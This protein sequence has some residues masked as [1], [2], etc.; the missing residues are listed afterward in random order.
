MFS[1][2]V[3]DEQCTPPSTYDEFLVSINLR[4]EDIMTTEIANPNL[5]RRA[6]KWLKQ[7]AA[8]VNRSERNNLIYNDLIDNSLKIPKI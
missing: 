2:P 7:I 1:E 3:I 4:I 8:N 6:I 5:A